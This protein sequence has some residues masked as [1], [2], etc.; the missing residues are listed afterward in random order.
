MFL[1]AFE[2]FT[3]AK[4]D[5]KTDYLI[6]FVLFRNVSLFIFIVYQLLHVNSVTEFIGRLLNFLNNENWRKKK[7]SSISDRKWLCIC[8]RLQ[9]NNVWN[10]HIYALDPIIYSIKKNEVQF[11]SRQVH[12]V[13]A[14]CF[15]HI[16]TCNIDQINDVDKKIH[17]IRLFVFLIIIIINHLRA[18]PIPIPILYDTF[19]FPL[20]T[21]VGSNRQMLKAKTIMHLYISMT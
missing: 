17:L 2:N 16:T 3:I 13:N 5:Y 20:K 11:V 12:V 18:N 4:I 7:S 14:I 8:L 6:I 21:R 10:I 19:G 1:K 15:L 9:F